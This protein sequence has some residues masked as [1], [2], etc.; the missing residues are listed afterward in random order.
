VRQV[1]LEISG[2]DRARLD[3]LLDPVR[4]T[5]QRLGSNDI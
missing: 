1:A 5:E 4:Q 2:L 3:E